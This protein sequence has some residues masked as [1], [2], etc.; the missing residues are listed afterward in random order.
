MITAMANLNWYRDKDDGHH[1][2]VNHIMLNS[3]IIM[4][5]SCYQYIVMCYQY[6]V[7]HVMIHKFQP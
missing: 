7:M 2:M 3:H 6:I 1:I 5:F 4:S